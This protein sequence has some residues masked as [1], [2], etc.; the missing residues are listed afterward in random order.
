MSLSKNKGT[1]GQ[2]SPEIKYGGDTSVNKKTDLWSL[3]ILLYQLVKN[4]HPF[5]EMDYD[6]AKN[7][8]KIDLESIQICIIPEEDPEGNGR[9]FKGMGPWKEAVKNLLPSNQQMVSF[10]TKKSH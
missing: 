6:I 3:G 5:G 2:M 8:G 1:E 7:L 9:D 10:S 4:V